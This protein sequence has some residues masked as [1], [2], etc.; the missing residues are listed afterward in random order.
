MKIKS[1][2]LLSV[3][4]TLAASFCYS[5]KSFFHALP[6]IEQRPKLNIN[7]IVTSTDS[8]FFG[9]RPVASLLAYSLPNQNLQAGAGISLQRLRYTYAT[10][11]YYTDYSISLVGF[12][13][14][15][16]APS[17]PSGV[18]SIGLLGG[19]LNNVV[20]IGPAYNFSPIATA[21]KWQIMVALGISFNN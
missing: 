9:V 7:P 21:H 17:T 8:T 15:T 1:I 3:I 2:L 13:G 11:S 14:G 16:L 6:K 5:Q 10:Q 4:F 18:V 12:A 20:Q 19:I